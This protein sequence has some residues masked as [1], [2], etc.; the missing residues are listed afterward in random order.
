MTAALA[1]SPQL[2]ENI[3]AQFALNE[4]RRILVMIFGSF[5]PFFVC[6]LSSYM[7]H[8]TCTCVCGHQIKDGIVFSSV[9][10]IVCC[11]VCAR[12][13]FYQHQFFSLSSPSVVPDRLWRIFWHPCRQIRSHGAIYVPAPAI[14]GNLQRDLRRFWAWMERCTQLGSM[15]V[16][17]IK[18]FPSASAVAPE[19]GRTVGK[20]FGVRRI[21]EVGVWRYR[22][23]S[24]TDTFPWQRCPLSRLFSS[25]IGY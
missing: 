1:A 13:P 25:C 10:G 23:F 22:R 5:P 9:T 18:S 15:K 6:L 3:Y 17:L 2:H 20:A 14:S 8:F 16:P 24:T 12:P 7:T 19:P 11:W 21:W 4:V